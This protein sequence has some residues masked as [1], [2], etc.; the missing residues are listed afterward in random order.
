MA[1]L[2]REA[3]VLGLHWLEPKLPSGATLKDMVIGDDID[4]LSI[5]MNGSFEESKNILGQTRVTDSGYTPTINVDSYHANPSDRIYPFLLDLA[6]NRKSGID[7]KCIMVEMIIDHTVE[8]PEE[9]APDRDEWYDTW[10]EYCYVEIVSYGGAAG[11]SLPIVYNI[12]PCGGRIQTKGLLSKDSSSMSDY[13]GIDGMINFAE[14]L[15]R[16]K[17]LVPAAETSLS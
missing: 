14:D 5:E 15:A 7:A 4:D 16:E 13:W 6:M 8:W 17:G 12:H 10:M 3:H 9:G 11:G 2:K 1:K